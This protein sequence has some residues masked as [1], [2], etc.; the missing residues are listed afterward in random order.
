MSEP[1]IEIMIPTLNE[2]GHIA[3]AV[4]N[5]SKVGSVL[6]V[7]SCSTDGTQELARQ[8]GA[9]VVEHAFE[10]YA[11]Q[12][13]WALANL[14]WRGKWVFILDADERITPGL[15]EEM[16]R[17]AGSPDAADGYFVN[18]LMVFMGQP[19]RHGG[20]YPSWNLRFFKRGHCRYEDRAVHEH[21]LCDGRTEY[22]RERL[23]HIRR[24]TV[25]QYIT[26]HIRYA[27]LESDE[28]VRRKLG[29]STDAPAERLFRDALR[30]RQW[31][32]RE[33]WPQLPG[34]PSKM[35][36]RTTYM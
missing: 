2:A 14:P 4:A 26:K 15:R 30:L 36:M 32:R 9:T 6:V 25:S 8:A 35:P 13:N 20:L 27:D 1:L 19:V 33:V 31:L 5:A 10:G 3:A 34:R 17:I 16:L 23:I 24:E 29:Q 18:R 7:D 11:R 21:M 22:L 12:K 28:W